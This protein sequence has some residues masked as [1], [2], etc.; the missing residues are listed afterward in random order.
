MEGRKEAL[1][2]NKC[3]KWLKR[4]NERAETEKQ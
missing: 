4:T 3:G 1:S 2:L